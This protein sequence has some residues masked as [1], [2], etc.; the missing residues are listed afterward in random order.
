MA[1]RL[2][3]LTRI[4]EDAGSIPGL[5]QWVESRRCRELWC[6][7]QMRSGNCIA[8]AEAQAGSYS[9]DQTPAWEPPYAAGAA[10]KKQKKEKRKRKKDI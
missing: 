3:K 9:S 7:P 10:L 6:K 2:K 1:Q 5:A 4:L 8:V